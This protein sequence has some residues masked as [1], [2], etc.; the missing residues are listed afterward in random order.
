MKRGRL[1]IAAATIWSA[2]PLPDAQGPAEAWGASLR[3]RAFAHSSSRSPTRAVELHIVVRE[4]QAVPVA[5]PDVVT[6]ARVPRDHAAAVE[7]RSAR[8]RGLPGRAVRVDG[9]RARRR[10]PAAALVDRDGTD[11][12]RQH[13][14]RAPAHAHPR[15]ARARREVRADPLRFVRAVVIAYCPPLHARPRFRA[16]RT[17]GRG[18]AL[19]RGPPRGARRPSSRLA[20]L[21]LR[22]RPAPPTSS[23]TVPGPRPRSP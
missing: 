2:T 22:R 17:P 7:V 19:R 9:R 23:P 6:Q 3:M 10:P 12:P 11:T 21:P 14:R 5:R 16:R 18:R 15:A 1:A 4:D 20:T 13:R 8:R